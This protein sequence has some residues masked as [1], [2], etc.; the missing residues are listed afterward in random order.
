[1]SKIQILGTGGCGFLRI[2]DMFKNH[3]GI[4]Y[5]GGKRKFQNGF[6]VWNEQNDL[7]WEVEK[8]SEPERLSRITSQDLSANISH[9]TL[10][11]VDEILKIDPEMKFFCLR[12]REE[13]TIKT[14]LS[15]WGYR[16]PCFVKDRGLGV[17]KNR[18]PVDQFPNFSNEENELLATIKY[19]KT[20]QEISDALG[21]KYPDNFRIVDSALFFSDSSY[22]REILSFFGI[23]IPFYHNPI[24]Y[25]DFKITTTLHGGLGNNL[26]Q[27]AEIV[28]FCEKWK[29]TDPVFGTWDLWDNQKFPKF[30]NCDRFIGGHFG[31]HQ[32]M[33]KTFPNLEWQE[34]LVA[35]FDVK[36][37]VNDMFRFGELKD[38]QKVRERFKIKNHGLHE[39]ASLHL[40]FCT[41]PADDHVNGVV[42][43]EFYDSVF[44]EI[45][46]Y[47]KFLVFSDDANLASSAIDRFSQKYSR[48]F[49]LQN[50]GSFESL[51]LMASCK[52]NVMHVSTFSFWGAFLLSDEIEK[53]VYCPKAFVGAHGPKMIPE[54]L[55][56]KIL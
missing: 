54:Q 46:R 44:N 14:L 7:I 41:R 31:S 10:R 4:R 30:Y 51:E 34:S 32:D 22:Q 5:K 25:S 39:C 53:F 50:I 11:W 42:T 20:Y 37:C 55:G 35:D 40:R 1:M 12:G 13:F 49:E 2:Y 29:L 15:S 24:N 18:Y 36:F 19:V 48:D 26:F 3:F 56:W 17:G 28:S 43:E 9:V 21:E 27:M 45:P 33:Q 47:V 6:E 52:Y 16:N 23:E 8:L 38:F